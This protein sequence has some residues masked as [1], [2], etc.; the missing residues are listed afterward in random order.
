VSFTIRPATQDDTYSLPDIE[1]SAS[2]AYLA[3][4]E[5]AWIASAE[6]TSS[7]KHR[8]LINNGIIWVCVN[9]SDAPVGFLSA[10]QIGGNLHI[11]ELS[12]RR[13]VQ[14]LGIGRALIAEAARWARERNLSALTL[15]TFR[16]VPWTQPFYHRLSFRTVEAD[17]LSPELANIMEAE[18]K[19][20]LKREHRCAMLYPLF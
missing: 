2:T 13:E 9:P 17:K 18:E 6:V 3:L 15:T 16:D 20:G 10:E 12:V 7:E 19:N 5:L 1:R 14:G 8:A 11:A 4:A